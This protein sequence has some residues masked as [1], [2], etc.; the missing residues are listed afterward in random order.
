MMETAE[1]LRGRV[2]ALNVTDNQAA[3]MRL[4]TLAACVHLKQAGH[5]PILQMTCRDR[6]RLALESD[7]PGRLHRTVD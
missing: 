6:N 4:S 3:V 2:D 1:M 5:D 7:L